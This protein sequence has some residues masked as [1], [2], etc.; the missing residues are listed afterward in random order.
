MNSR[1]IPAP[2][3]RLAAALLIG[4]LSLPI[5]VFTA[6]A[7]T[8]AVSVQVSLSAEEI[9]PGAVVVVDLQSTWINAHECPVEAAGSLDVALVLETSARVAGTRL[10]ALKVAALGF[11]AELNSATD[12][13]AIVTYDSAANIAYPLTASF[14]LARSAIVRFGASGS[15][16]PET[17]LAAAESLLYPED[18]GG[19]ENAAKTIVLFLASPTDLEA[20]Q[21]ASDALKARGARVI[22]VALTGVDLEA[23][24]AIA[25]GPDSV[26]VAQ[27]TRDL[28]QTFAQ[29]ASLAR[30]LPVAASDITVTLTADS[31]RFSPVL[32]DRSGMLA[33][34]QITWQIPAQYAATDLS[35]S[36]ALRAGD[37][38]GAGAIGSLTIA[39]TPCAGEDAE[40]VTL[41]PIA[42]PGAQIDADAPDDPAVLRLADRIGEQAEGSMERFSTTRYLIDVAAFTLFSIEVVGAGSELIPELYGIEAI[43]PPLFSDS[44]LSDR[45][46]TTV[47]RL[48]EPGPYWLYVT[49]AREG[50][51]GD[52]T[53]T[54]AADETQD[55]AALNLGGEALQAAQTA[56]EGRAYVLRGAR[57]GQFVTVTY[58]NPGDAQAII[59][60]TSL[61]GTPAVEE[62][63]RLDATNFQY[64]AVFRMAGDPPYRLIVIGAGT[65]TVSAVSGDLLRVERGLIA[66]GDTLTA[67]IAAD[68]VD[69]WQ[70]NAAAGQRLTLEL[71]AESALL[72]QVRD[73]DNGIVIETLVRA[74]DDPLA[75][76]AEQSG[77]YRLY[78]R[79]PDN[80]ALDYILTLI[81]GDQVQ[82]AQAGAAV[83]AR[84]RPLLPETRI[85][86]AGRQD[87]WR[88]EGRAGQTVV[89]QMADTD[90]ELD[91]LLTLIGPGGETVAFNDDFRGLDAQIGPL[92]L[93]D[94]GQYT[95]QAGGFGDSEGEYELLLILF[96]SDSAIEVRPIEPVN[97][98]SGPGN[99]FL[100]EG[101][102]ATGET[103]I[104]VERDETSSWLH[105]YSEEYGL[106]WVDVARVDAGEADIAA[107]P[108]PT[109]AE[110]IAL[111]TPIPDTVVLPTPTVVIATNEFCVVTA[112]GNFTNLRARPSV[113]SEEM[114][115]LQQGETAEADG[116]YFDE[117][118]FPWWRL[119]A[120]G[121]W[122]RADVV[123]ETLPCDTL[124]EVALD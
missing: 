104:A 48:S 107:L 54:L 34:D 115:E 78:L 28:T 99:D 3:L 98:R 77:A 71:S 39:Y 91:S 76:V 123:E 53:L 23:A 12:Q 32:A 47:Y 9:A 88:F 120:T 92:R 33:G 7:Q 100:A 55:F 58:S 94:D 57:E 25:D 17:G 18:G 66:P 41:D 6:H 74:G 119:S 84:I 43:Y 95:I 64:Q 45:R 118:G 50:D 69:S 51:D 114:A 22:V 37:E 52:F 5:A 102:A 109:S 30:G 79:T 13:A 121:Y 44:A 97:L 63:T 72:A 31:D 10:A 73:P 65:Y 1:H 26:L 29:A 38:P 4:C 11:L 70:I 105:V 93:A 2:R 27:D 75:V 89:I 112:L 15:A 56:R 68:R 116:V 16:L 36:A 59:T 8:A 117:D 110:A 67:E 111:A 83:D 96:D 124:P 24:Q 35:L 86:I 90:G 49:S 87:V 20:A 40:P 61:D 103:L 81:A 82:V 46:R 113:D 108:E 62:Y 19:R 106:L 122:V 60:A 14:S 21:T 42:L 101:S 80:E 85:L